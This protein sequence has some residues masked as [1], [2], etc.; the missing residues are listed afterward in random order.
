MSMN[1][2]KFSDC[3]VDVARR[4]LL[5]GGKRQPIQPKVFDVLIY[6]LAHQGRVIAKQELQS[7]VWKR[8]ALS[9]SVI[10]RT[11]MKVRK[12]IGDDNP[13]RPLIRTF[14]GIGYC[15]LSAERLAPNLA[16]SS[17]SR[18]PL[19]VAIL[20]AVDRT[21]RADLGWI[22]L[23]M[24]SLL[25]Q[26]LS[27]DDNIHITSAAATLTAVDAARMK[28]EPSHR[29]PEAVFHTLGLDVVVQLDVAATL[30]GYTA[31]C[32]VYDAQ[33]FR[34]L[35]SVQA[36]DAASLLPG[37]VRILL[38]EWSTNLSSR[39]RSTSDATR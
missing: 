12:A 31:G 19:H 10:A 36:E 29:L 24:M 14:H 21:A 7:A 15:F 17:Q 13:S 28:G 39:I 3:E 6:L 20:P 5:L 11:L 35:E 37:L 18:K 16:S 27:V 2:Y 1:Q 9:D 38:A 4:E 32:V 30:S 34:R 23:G 26:A 25:A 22:D 8:S 33:G